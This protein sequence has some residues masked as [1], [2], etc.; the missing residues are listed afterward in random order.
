M[1][2]ET[3]TVVEETTDNTTDYINAIKDLKA[4]TVAKDQYNKLKEENKQLLTA[5]ANGDYSMAP[6]P[7]PEIDV[8]KIRSEL[9]DSENEYTNLNYVK[10]VL[11]L[12]EGIIEQGGKDPFLPYGKDII[13]S[14]EDIATANRVA[15]VLQDC[16]DYA[17]GNSDIFTSELQ[18]VMVD[19]VPTRRR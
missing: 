15:K 19:T 4:N 13:V 1:D 16:I 5:L 3:N 10:K 7:E 11:E 9:F 2:N 8:K 14:D 18:R 17:D 12:R 6:Q